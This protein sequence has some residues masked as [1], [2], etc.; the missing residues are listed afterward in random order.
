MSESSMN[1]VLSMSYLFI[2]T[3]VPS[4]NERRNNAF[5]LVGADKALIF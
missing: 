5:R 3:D 2:I 1:D 4:S